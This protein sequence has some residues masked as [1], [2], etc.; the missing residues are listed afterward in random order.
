MSA[1]VIASSAAAASRAVAPTPRPLARRLVRREGFLPSSRRRRGDPMPVVVASAAPPADASPPAVAPAHL[2]ATVTPVP[3]EV[4]AAGG[5]LLA[6][7]PGMAAGFGELTAHDFL[8][9]N[10][11]VP[12]LKVLCVDPPVCV[13]EDF[14][15][16]EQCDALVDAAGR[17]GR[18]ASAPSAASTRGLSGSKGAF[19]TPTTRRRTRS[20]CRRW[21]TTRAGSI[22]KRTRTRFRKRVPATVLVYLNDVE[23]G[24]ARGSRSSPVLPRDEGVHAGPADVTHRRGSGARAREVDLATVGVRAR[25]EAREGP[26]RRRRRRRRRRAAAAAAAAAAEGGSRPSRT[27]GNLCRHPAASA[28]CR[29]RASR[30]QHPPRRRHS[31]IAIGAACAPPTASESRAR[32]A[33]SLPLP[34]SLLAK[35]R[36]GDAARGVR[37]ASAEEGERG[38]RASAPRPGSASSVRR[39][40]PIYTGSHTTALARWTPIL[41][42]FA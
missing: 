35:E 1:V 29:H 39:P 15:T 37:G 5:M 13:V 28:Q 8:R 42:D 14:L 32:R 25:G 16:A 3:P 30:R 40:A 2:R 24:G 9:V 36:L 7:Q 19:K 33:G 10:V 18:C 17:A 31:R 11:D 27:V 22:S 26:R 38:A 12:N 34:P 21:R 41:K 4:A 20:S 6:D 23:E